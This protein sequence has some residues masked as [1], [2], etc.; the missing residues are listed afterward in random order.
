[1]AATVCNL[2]RPPYDRH[3]SVWRCNRSATRYDR[4]TTAIRPPY[5]CN[6]AA[7]YLQP[8]CNLIRPPYVCLEVCL[9]SCLV[10]SGFSCC[11]RSATAIRLQPPYVCLERVQPPYVCLEVCNLI[12]PPYVC[13]EVQPDCNLIR[14]PYDCN[15]ERRPPYVIHV[16]GDHKICLRYR[17]YRRYRT[18]EK[19]RAGEALFFVLY[20]YI[21][22]I[23]GLKNDCNQDQREKTIKYID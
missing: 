22:N 13:L 3:T 16:I 17:R 7:K 18:L 14:P 23:D 1:M 5:D 2:I 11:N 20:L 6:R 19:L 10:V 21:Y 9:F 4:H 15:Q 12:R 8:D